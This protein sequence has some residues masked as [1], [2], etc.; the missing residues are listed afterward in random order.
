MVIPNNTHYYGTCSKAFNC[1]PDTNSFTYQSNRRLGFQQRLYYEYLYTQKVSGQTFFY[2]LTYNDANIPIFL[3]RPCFSY[4]HI[5][6][7]TNGRLSKVLLRKYGSRLRYLCACESGEGKGKRGLGNNPHYHFIFFVQPVHDKNNN[8]IMENYIPISPVD[9]RDLLQELWQGK[10]GYTDWKKAKFGHVEEGKNLGVVQSVDCFKYVSK[11]VTK[12]TEEMKRENHVYLYYYDYFNSLFQ[13]DYSLYCYYRYLRTFYNYDKYLFIDDFKLIAFNHCRKHHSDFT[14][15]YWLKE[16]VPSGLALFD[17]YKEWY[18]SKFVPQ[19]V[20]HFVSEYRNNYSSKV[21]CSKS[22]GFYGLNFIEDVITNPHFMIP[23]KEG[24]QICLPSLYYIRKLFYEVKR[25]P[26]TNNPLYILN[27]VG[28]RYKCARIIP[29]I[30]HFADS[31]KELVSFSCLN[32]ISFD[33]KGLNSKDVV[34]YFIDNNLYRLYSIWHNVYQYRSFSSDDFNYLLSSLSDEVVVR[35]YEFFL[36]NSDMY[37]LDYHLCTISQVVDSDNLSTNTLPIF[38]P[39][40]KV[41]DFM[42]AFI[43]DLQKH[44]SDVSKA[45]FKDKYIHV[46]SINRYFFNCVS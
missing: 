21:R 13:S 26:V 27:A 18:F 39:Y 42:D 2:T 3:D 15:H 31:V 7:I 6:Y 8:P 29:S 35:D 40:L 37:K 36:R 1:V 25:C 33:F 10:K 19:A 17:K 32:D 28:V 11:Y 46:Q 23:S 24:Y 14:I 5:R 20:E 45:C 38:K 30:N 41:F 16:Y 34:R 12:D 44:R 22:L 43:D 4:K 9:F